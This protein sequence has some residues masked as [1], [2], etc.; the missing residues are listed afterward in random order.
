MNALVP[1]GGPNLAE[2][3]DVDQPAPGPGAAVIR[4]VTDP[5]GPTPPGRSPTCAT[6]ASEATP[7]AP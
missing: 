7:S 6:A 3:G 4:R 5:T 1:A 2:F